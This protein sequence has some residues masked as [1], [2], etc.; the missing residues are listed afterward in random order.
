[1]TAPDG[2]CPKCHDPLDCD[3]HIPP[4]CEQCRKKQPHPPTRECYWACAKV[5]T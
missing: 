2:R 4:A 3:G 1:M 5:T